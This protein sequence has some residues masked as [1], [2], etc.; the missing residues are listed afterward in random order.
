MIPNGEKCD[1]IAVKKLSALSRE[2]TSKDKTF[3]QNEKIDLHKKAC[4]NK[5][6]CDVVIPFEDTIILKSNQHQKV[7]NTTFIIYV[8]LESLIEKI[9]VCES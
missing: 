6:F 9:D 7:D 8:D 5:D 4:E 1:Y 2:I 3:F